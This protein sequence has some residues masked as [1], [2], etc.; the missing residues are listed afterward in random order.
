MFSEEYLCLHVHYMPAMYVQSA[1][2]DLHMY[3]VDG[4]S[5]A[6]WAST[7]VWVVSFDIWWRG[8]LAPILQSGVS[9]ILMRISVLNSVQFRKL[10]YCL[11]SETS[12]HRWWG[13]F[14][15][16]IWF[17]IEE[18]WICWMTDW[19]AWNNQFMNID[20]HPPNGG[21]REQMVLWDLFIIKTVMTCQNT[22]YPAL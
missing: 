3:S 17:S 9:T 5:L 6:D 15:L 22:N 12:L 10:Y 21:C 4:S 20:L 8:S 16:Q 2:I 13:K 7:A 14:N 18:Y 1:V 19:T 11:Q